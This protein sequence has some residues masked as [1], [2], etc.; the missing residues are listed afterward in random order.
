VVLPLLFPPDEGQR[1]RKGKLQV[2]RLDDPNVLEETVDG[3][4]STE[5]SLKFSVSPKGRLFWDTQL[6]WADAYGMSDVYD[7]NE[8]RLY[9][10]VPTAERLPGGKRGWGFSTARQSISPSGKALFRYSSPDGVATIY[11]IDTANILWRAGPHE[12]PTVLSSQEGLI[13]EETWHELWKKWLPNLKLETIAWRSLDT[14]DVICRTV[15]KTVIDPRHCNVNRSL[16]VTAD[17]SIYRLPLPVTWRLLAYCQ[18]ILALPLV[19]IWAALRWRR[20]R[21]AQRQPAEPGP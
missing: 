21:A 4:A 10:S 6:Y 15:A 16:F 8:R 13:V 3:P 19:L 9:S 1:K 2:W 20:R 11:E 17:G 5:G 12:T 7:F 18:A 14:G